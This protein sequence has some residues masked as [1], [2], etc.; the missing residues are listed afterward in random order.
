MAYPTCKICDAFLY[1]TEEPLLCEEC[2]GKKMINSMTDLAVLLGAKKEFCSE[3]EAFFFVRET[4]EYFGCSGCG[5]EKR[6][7]TFQKGIMIHSYGIDEYG[8]EEDWDG[9][10]ELFF[11]F[12]ENEWDEAMKTY[13]KKEGE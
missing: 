6:D 8:K 5:L 11:P 10:K 1:S 4:M 7:G 2:K 9:A 13:G 12:T 3:T